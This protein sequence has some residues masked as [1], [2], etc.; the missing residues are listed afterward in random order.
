MVSLQIETC[1]DLVYKRSNFDE[2]LAIVKEYNSKSRYRKRG[3]ALIPTKFGISFTAKFLNQ[4]RYAVVSSQR[5]QAIAMKPSN[6]EYSLICSNIKMNTE[7]LF[8]IQ[9][10]YNP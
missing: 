4:V 3:I 6:R 2:R 9:L 1:W 5:R 7:W 8:Y 10:T